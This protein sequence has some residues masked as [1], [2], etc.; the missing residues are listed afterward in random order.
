M[1]TQLN[2]KSYTELIEDDIRWINDKMPYPSLTKDHI[3][4][5]LKKSIEYEFPESDKIEYGKFFL[6]TQ[7]QIAEYE[8][9]EIRDTDI[10]IY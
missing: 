2:K 5:V 8:L 3:I 7:R 4:C 10:N 6:E 1:G 9:K